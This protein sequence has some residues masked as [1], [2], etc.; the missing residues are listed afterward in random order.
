VVK[1]LSLGR[2]VP[3][4]PASGLRRVI[5]ILALYAACTIVISLVGIGTAVATFWLIRGASLWSGP[6]FI[7]YAIG[8]VT[9]LWP[10][11][12]LISELERWRKR[13]GSIFR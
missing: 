6:G 12:Y 4:P 8:M 3:A 5:V 1:R 9:F 2:R 7:I 13:R 10:T 11:L